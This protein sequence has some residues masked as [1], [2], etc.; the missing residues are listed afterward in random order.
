[1]EPD[2]QEGLELWTAGDPEAA[3]DAL[4]YALE[5]CHEN[6]WIHVALGRL[7]LL[8][9]RDPVLARGHF[10]YAVELVRKAI[11]AGFSGTLPRQAARQRTILRSRPGACSVFAG[12][13]QVG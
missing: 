13:G 3:R 6:L 4:R 11:P 10:G 12:A 8:E 7:A 9:F 1:M 5:G 2:Y